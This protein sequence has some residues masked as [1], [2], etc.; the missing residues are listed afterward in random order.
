[1]LV[2]VAPRRRADTRTQCTRCLDG[3]GGGRV[4]A[5]PR[6][7]TEEAAL[8]GSRRGEDVDGVM[9]TSKLGLSR[10]K[11]TRQTHRWRCR[12]RTS[13][14][15]WREESGAAQHQRGRAQGLGARPRDARRQ[16]AGRR[17]NQDLVGEPTRG[18]QGLDRAQKAAANRRA[19]ARCI[20]GYRGPRRRR[21]GSRTSVRHA[22][23]P[24]CAVRPGCLN[25]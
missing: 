8:A 16:A 18:G 13:T 6:V 4:V 14:R 15:P 12:T 17:R 23:I 1:M 11:D 3:V 10:R 9:L 2:H 24:G 22:M 21:L 25:V 5:S 20:S 7:G 19:C